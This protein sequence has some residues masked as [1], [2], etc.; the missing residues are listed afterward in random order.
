MDRD[1]LRDRF[2]Q[3]YSPPNERD[4]IEVRDE[5]ERYVE[6]VARN[7]NAGSSAVGNAI[8]APRGRVRPWMEDGAMPDVVRGTDAADGK[9][10]FRVSGENHSLLTGLV[11]A[12]FAGGSIAEKTY[13]PSF[14][15]E[16]SELVETALVQLGAGT[17]RIDRESD[18]QGDELRP[19]RHAPVLGRI[20]A[21]RDAPTGRDFEAYNLP[22]YLFESDDDAR[23]FVEWYVA[24]R[25]VKADGRNHVRIYEF[26]RSD[27]Y[28]DDLHGIFNRVLNGEV[29]RVKRGVHITADAVGKNPMVSDYIE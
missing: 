26:N 21:A 10:W 19:A 15:A 16:D 29:T 3:T 17:D 9:G 5:Y 22:A 1:T 23:T 27:S 6:Y 11:A 13:M 8:G 2:A 24:L 7:S 4:P 28:H 14:S 18:S 12:T 20:L 25:G